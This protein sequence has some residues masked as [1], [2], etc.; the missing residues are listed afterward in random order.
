MMHS[1][2]ASA[3]LHAG[4]RMLTAAVLLLVAVHLPLVVWTGCSNENDPERPS[5]TG[6]VEG[7]VVELPDA[8]P[9]ADARLLLVDPWTLTPASP[10]AVTD[11]NG[12]YRFTEVT[13]GSYAI[14]VYH[15]RLCTFD[16][17]ASLV[18]VRSGVGSTQQIRLIVDESW[19]HSGYRIEGSVLDQETD[20]PVSG[21][22]VEGISL[23]SLDMDVLFRGVPG[24]WYGITDSLGRFSI[25]AS[26]LTTQAGE[27]YGLDPIS[28]TR[29][30][31]EPKTLAGDGPS[32]YGFP[33]ALPLPSGDDSTLTVQIRLVP[34]TPDGQGP[35]GTGAIRGRVTCLG[36]P[37][38]YLAVAVSLVSCM[39]PD[40]FRVSPCGI[41]VPIPARAKLTDAGGDFLIG[42]LVPGSYVVHPAYLDGDGYL[43]RP[44]ADFFVTVEEGE[45]T[46]VSVLEVQ[47][48]LEPVHPPDRAVIT[49]RRPELRWEA[50]PDTSGY[51]F[52]EYELRFRIGSSGWTVIG[53]LSEPRWEMPGSLAFEPGSLVRWTVDCIGTPDSLEESCF[54]SGFEHEATFTVDH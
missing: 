52:Q 18:Q 24:P 5:E 53:S 35:H 20:E 6:S 19:S 26:I 49:D 13:P 45:T 38:P 25:R 4:P 30:G 50:G 54:I 46:D 39:E 43:Y 12:R 21:A 28:V 34:L 8:E 32:V 40:T 47:S 51:T 42:R 33:P 41:A 10:L 44:S 17:T 3:G 2:I 1:P 29:A 31:Y 15:D 9:V 27:V 11:A 48:A 7:S 37:V 14:F 23:S 22:F 36:A 16:R